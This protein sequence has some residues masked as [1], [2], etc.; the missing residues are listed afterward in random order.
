MNRI[1]AG[2]NP[3]ILP[4]EGGGYIFV[5]QDH[6]L[7]EGDDVEI[8]PTPFDYRETYTSMWSGS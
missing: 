6:N 8:F 1:F 7:P 5:D 4:S 3:A 2:E